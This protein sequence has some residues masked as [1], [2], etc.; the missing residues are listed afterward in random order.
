M[1]QQRGENWDLWK[2]PMVSMPDR[3]CLRYSTVSQG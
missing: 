2:N 1:E 3:R